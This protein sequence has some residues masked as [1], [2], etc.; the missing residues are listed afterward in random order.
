MSPGEIALFVVLVP[1]LV[2]AVFIVAAGW[3]ARRAGIAASGPASGALALGAGAIAS[4]L[5]NSPPAFPPIEVTDRI[6]WLVL[7]ACLLGLCESIRPGPGWTRWENRLLLIL[8]TM[9]LILGPVLGP[10]W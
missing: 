8:L 10:D 4:F 6:P 3:A 2:A 5:G 7:A 1:S 9:A